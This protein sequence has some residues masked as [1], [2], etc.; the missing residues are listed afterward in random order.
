MLIRLGYELAIECDAATPII[1]LLDIHPDRHADIKRQRRF[2]TSPSV[3]T[4][5]YRDSHGNI[6]RRFTVPA[7][8]FRILFDGV[9]E[10]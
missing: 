3:P 6:C 9:V 10:D 8:G 2:L 1:A 7:G 5:T 4:T